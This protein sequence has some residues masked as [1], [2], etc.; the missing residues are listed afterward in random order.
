MRE[1]HG[2]Y[3]GRPARDAYTP[4]DT[5]ATRAHDGPTHATQTIE[6]YLVGTQFIELVTH[7]LVGTVGVTVEELRSF[8]TRQSGFRGEHRG[9]RREKQRASAQARATPAGA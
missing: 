6:R 4:R 2:W 7:G 8:V 3:R 5:L 1:L 9:W